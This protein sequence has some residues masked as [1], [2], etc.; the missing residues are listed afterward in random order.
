MDHRCIYIMLFSLIGFNAL[1]QEFDEKNFTLYSTKDG[2]SHNYI[3]SITQ[4]QYGYI[5]IATY[6]GLN[7]FDGSTFQQFYSDSGSNSLPQNLLLKLK[8]LDAKQLA[9]PT[10]SGL[11]IINIENLAGQNIFITADP[12]HPTYDVNK[13]CD[14]SSGNSGDIFVITTSGFYHF[15]NKKELIFRFDY[16]S[17]VHS[18]KIYSFGWNINKI[19]DN[20]L[21][22]STFAGPYIYKIAQKD[23]HPVNETD[24]PLYRRMAES[25]KLM[26]GLKDIEYTTNVLVPNENNF[27]LF[28][29]PTQKEYSIE[30]PFPIE[31]NF[32]GDERATFMQLNDTTFVLNSKKNGFYLIHYDRVNNSYQFLPQLFFD[33]YICNSFLID[34]NKRLW[35]ATN[36]GL[37]KEKRSTGITEQV[38]LNQSPKKEQAILFISV[39]NKK[40]FAGTEN[41]LLILESGSLK[42]MAEIDLSN[43]G[44]DFENLFF[45]S[46]P[47]NKDTLFTGVAGFWV[48]TKNLTHGRIPLT[49]L[50]TTFEGIDLLFTD[51]RNAAYLKKGSSNTFYYREVKEKFRTLNYK[52]QLSRIGLVNT[53]A[54]DPDGNIWFGGWGIQ[55]FNYRLQQFDT[56]L[57]SYPK[58]N[59]FNT[60]LSSNIV[61]DKRG[62]MYFGT[63]EN[64]LIIYDLVA[65]K[66]THLTRKEGLPD[67]T[68]H[69]I[70]IHHDKIWMG[71]ESGLANYDITTKKI[72]SFGVSDGVPTD[73][74][75]T[76]FLYY[77]SSS[78][79]LYGAFRNIVFH[80][81]P[82]KLTKNDSPPKFFIESI[83]TGGNDKIYHPSE[84]IDLSYRENNVV[85]NLN[86]INF[87]DAYQQ[88][89][90]Y[91][92]LKNNN[93]PW[94]ELG[95]Q[96]SIIF[97]DLSPGIHKLQVKVYTRNQNWPEQVQ[98]I[99][100]N[101]LPPFWKTTWFVTSTVA[102][103]LGILYFFYRLRIRQIRQKADVDK[104]LAQTEMKALHAQMNPHFIFNCL[105]SIRQMILSNENK[106]AS[107]YLNKFA[108]LIRITLNQ[109]S[110]PFVS[111][112][113]TLDY[114][115]LYLEMEKIRASNFTHTIEVDKD[116][117]PG[118]IMLPP[119]L[120]QPFIENAIWHGVTSLD[121]PMNIDIHFKKDDQQLL[122]VVEDDGIGI[123]RSL[124]LK[125]TQL[126]HNS[127][128][129]DNIKQR[130]RVLNEKYNLQST[131]SIEDKSNLIPKNGTGTI[132]TLR[133]PIK[134]MNL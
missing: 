42:K 84:S 33:G 24:E 94:Q 71:T 81:N 5:W 62:R 27:S 67:N 11:H 120:I 59:N 63:W 121:E 92:L 13:I 51:S 6:K 65:K 37:F 31:D 23:L 83:V 55:R 61:F 91:R 56:I 112:E 12:V 89:F 9:I 49:Q 98:D 96:R 130:I 114:L 117:V 7:R 22:L 64:G 8:W 4:D 74:M 125:E 93:E 126:G 14:A 85:V 127:V 82:D 28:D 103:L 15:N 45:C 50:D 134:P 34:N 75:A 105:N 41:G 129:I 110:K 21:L 87:E 109:S 2:L 113:N 107:H 97:S 26:T 111:L 57:N 119:M 115:Q 118:E 99:S 95:S 66:F 133:L 40:V 46:A 77:D 38:S 47:V 102:L 128:G 79:Q 48:N 116:L 35:I 68:I 86:S 80:F 43:K 44:T 39:A 32:S 106:Q 122:C 72:S 108:Q 124:R 90:A 10:F 36:K 132:V 17:G 30:A 53:M 131:I 70:C 1:S 123:E 73:P 78:Q 100:I 54:E 88:Q 20:T 29:I 60:S 52:K 76:Y 25:K 58:F 3:N 101:I 104:A 19:D 16:F 69:A 18:S